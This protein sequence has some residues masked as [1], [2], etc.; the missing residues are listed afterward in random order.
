[1]IQ[2]LSLRRNIIEL[3]SKHGVI[4]NYVL[5]FILAMVV[6]III[7]TAIGL[8][9]EEFSILFTGA[10]GIAF[11]FLVSLIFA[12]SP[13]VLSLFLIVAVLSL[14]LSAV[15]EIAVFVFLFLSL[16]MLFYARLSPKKAMVILAMVL[17]FY[18]HIPYAVVIFAGLYIG[19]SAITPIILGTITWSFLPFL[20]N[21]AREVTVYNAAS[22]D[23]GLINFG[24][25]A[26]IYEILTTNL[27]W[28]IVAFVF[29]MIVLAVHLISRLAINFSRE[30]SI[31][32]GGFLGLV[33]LMMIMIMSD[34]NITF[35][36]L[37]IGILISFGLVWV[38]KF[39]D[40]ILDYGRVERVCFDD[41]DNIYYVKIVPKIK[42]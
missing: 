27:A 17:G 39:F 6:F 5:K 7:N 28:L 1:M 30:V 41:E 26:Q 20:T 35:P 3:Y 4:I 37:I 9:R 8:H 16:I 29:S 33:S 21:L 24:V 32:A 12:V 42:K 15:L 36:S 40:K 38:V 14:Q 2:L 22:G 13:P 18:F 23:A 34:I 19:A 31:I 10:T 25:F 11:T